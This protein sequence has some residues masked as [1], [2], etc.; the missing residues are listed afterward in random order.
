MTHMVWHKSSYSG[1]SGANCVEVAASWRKSTYSS[2]SGDNCV[3]VATTAPSIAV[4]DSK[5]PDGAKLVFGA[6]EWLVFTRR[7]KDG[8][9]RG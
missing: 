9:G 1:S 2:S 5:D 7:V 3:E 4:R 8:S 6:A